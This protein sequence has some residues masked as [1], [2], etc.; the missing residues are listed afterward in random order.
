MFPIVGVDVIISIS[1]E[2]EVNY[3]LPISLH[4][5]IDKSMELSESS[6]SISGE[7]NVTVYLS[8]AY[9]F[10]SSE[11]SVI[12]TC[13]SEVLSVSLPIFIFNGNFKE[14]VLILFNSHGVP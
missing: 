14:S 10:V 4:L 12:E 8:T 6:N 7:W 2:F 9:I 5:Y 13:L 11:I 1:P 3:T